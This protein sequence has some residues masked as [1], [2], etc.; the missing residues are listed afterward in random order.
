M[1]SLR[2]ELLIYLRDGRVTLLLFALGGLF[3][4][5]A[6]MTGW[7]QHSYR[8]AGIRAAQAEY[9]R[10]LG[11]PKKYAHSA[12]HYGMWAFKTPTVLAGM[13][14]GITAHVGSAVWME[15]HQ[16][17]ELLHRPAQDAGVSERFGTLS[18]AVV[19]GT[20]AP[21]LLLLMGFGTV[22]RE[23]ESGTWILSLVQGRSVARLV[24]AKAAVLGGLALLALLP[25]LI[26]TAAFMYSAGAPGADTWQRFVL[27]VLGAAVYLAVVATLIVALSLRIRGAARVLGIGLAL[28]VVAVVLVP[29]FTN[30][31]VASVAPLQTQQAFSR[32]LKATLA[33][34]DV[35]GM[36]RLEELTQRLLRE[37]AVTE[38]AKL[39]V[40]LAGT[41][42]Q[43]GENHGNAVF[44]QR[45]SS[46]F[47]SIDRQRNLARA[48]GIVSPAIAFSALSQ[49]ATG[50]DFTQHRAFVVQAE[51]HRRMMQRLMNAEIDRH[52]EVDGQRHLSDESIWRSVPAFEFQLPRLSAL[53]SQWLS[54]LTVMGGWL[55]VAALVL[56]VLAQRESR[57][58]S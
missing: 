58:P 2:K 38:I 16:Q 49:T 15:A 46:L 13:D 14:P 32:N 55:L 31:M 12:A 28:W 37:H 35:E 50:S 9:A 19:V 29:R 41:R 57:R 47:D 1:N 24:W 34:P 45:W 30:G 52:P 25:G 54:S 27:W 6:L 8:D 22:A 48:A 23:R 21:L 43:I 11:Q 33:A 53:R 7:Q 51:D 4:A 18:P 3:L 5:A 42:I 56:T 40:N 10:W 26:A 17:N 44:D 39:P 20:F 36:R